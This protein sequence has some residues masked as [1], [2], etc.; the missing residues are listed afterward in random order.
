MEILR[1]DKLDT[2]RN[3]TKHNYLLGIVERNIPDGANTFFQK[4][5]TKHLEITGQI[6]KSSALSD[7]EII[8]QDRIDKEIQTE[9]FYSK[10]L[11]DMSDVCK[12]FCDLQNSDAVDFC[13]SSQR[14]CRRYH[15]DN[16]PH[17][18]LVTYA[19]KGTEWL[20]EEAADRNAFANGEPNEKIVKDKSAL[21]FLKEWDVAVF[22]GGK[23]GLL[24]RTPDDALKEPSVLLRLD[25]P[26]YWK[27]LLKHQKQNGEYTVLR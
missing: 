13:L 23:N 2:L 20:P 7:F 24:H 22:C 9:A 26:S 4:L 25:H 21:Q 11:I 18:M 1:T 15:I 3:F 5:M 14:G 19:G 27:N 8:F 12:I 16:V 17:R 10:W 6:R